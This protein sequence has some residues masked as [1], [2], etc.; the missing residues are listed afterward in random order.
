MATVK[1][2]YMW[3][4]PVRNPIFENVGIIIKKCSFAK[5]NNRDILV[6]RKSSE[7]NSMVMDCVNSLVKFGEK[8]KHEI[9]L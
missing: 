2:A 1:D 5:E 8:L 6:Y 7:S 4:P 3:V 9:V